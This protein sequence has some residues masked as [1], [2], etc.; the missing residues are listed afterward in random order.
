M[1]AL[2]GD[3]HAGEGHAGEGQAG[4]KVTAMIVSTVTAATPRSKLPRRS[5]RRLAGDASVVVEEVCAGL[6]WLE[7]PARVT[8]ANSNAVKVRVNFGHPL[9]LPFCCIWLAALPFLA[10]REAVRAVLRQYGRRQSQR[11]TAKHQR[12]HP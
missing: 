12:N 9:A 3:G 4:E 11:D 2:T 5:W 6:L 7:G 1:A 8:S 10:L